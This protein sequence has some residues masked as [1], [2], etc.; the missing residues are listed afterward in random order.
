M[1]VATHAAI[2]AAVLNV[3]VQAGEPLDSAVRWLLVVGIAIALSSIA[4]MMRTVAGSEIHQRIRRIGSW[5]ALG[6]AVAVIPL[7]FSG[8]QAIPL[9]AILVL[10]MLAPVASGFWVWVKTSE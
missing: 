9:L 1:L 8:L 7:V 2:G 5:V 10:I 3:V 4:F 6:S